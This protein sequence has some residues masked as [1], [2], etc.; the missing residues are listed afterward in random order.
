MRK[1]GQ[2]DR[3]QISELVRR[4]L[5]KYPQLGEYM[6]RGIINTRALARA[7]LPEVRREH[8]GEV[9]LQSMVTAVRRFPASKG[10]PEREGLPR[11]LSGSDVNLRYDVGAVTVGLNS[12]TLA[13]VKGLPALGGLIMIQ[14]IE[15][16]TV[17]AEEERLNDLED[18]FAGDVI[19]MKRSL[20]SIVVK[21]PREITQTAGVIAHLANVLALERINIVEMMSSYT[22]TCFVV[23]EERALRCV[24]IIR[25][26]IKRARG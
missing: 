2:G 19:E 25:E 14:G 17:V 13:K 3:T 6:E 21:S 10:R 5:A 11:I 9:K 8:G 26:E 1:R 24:E 16:L 22:E 15:T 7:I 12:G 18:L 23:E 20:A 4:A